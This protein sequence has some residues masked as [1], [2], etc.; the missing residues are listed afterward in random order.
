MSI[1]AALLMEGSLK[2]ISVSETCPTLRLTS[3]E[4]GSEVRLK[5]A[6]ARNTS[7][8]ALII[9]TERRLPGLGAALAHALIFNTTL[10]TLDITGAHC[11]GKAVSLL[12]E[13]LKKNRSLTSLLL[14]TCDSD[15]L[16]ALAD[17]LTQNDTLSTLTLGEGIISEE[18]ALAFAHTIQAN[19][20][21]TVLSHNVCMT[22]TFHGTDNFSSLSITVTTA[23][24]AHAL[25]RACQMNDSLE[26]LMLSTSICHTAKPGALEQLLRDNS[27]LQRLELDSVDSREASALA[28]GLRNNEVLEK[29]VIKKQVGGTDG[30]W[31]LAHILVNNIGLQTFVLGH[32]NSENGQSWPLARA[33]RTNS[34]L[35]SLT[36]FGPILSDAACA[37][38]GALASNTSLRSLVILENELDEAGAWTL[39]NAI[40]KN[41]SLHNVSLSNGTVGDAGAKAF[42]GVIAHNT[43]LQYLDL[44]N[45]G[46]SG[47]GILDIVH[48]LA[49]NT[50][51]ITLDLTGNANDRALGEE[52]AKM[53]CTVLFDGEAKLGY[54]IQRITR[55]SSVQHRSSSSSSSDVGSI[56]R[57]SELETKLDAIKRELFHK[58]EEINALRRQLR[59]EKRRS[60]PRY[61]ERANWRSREA[62]VEALLHLRMDV[63]FV[64]NWRRAEDM[65][66]RPIVGAAGNLF[67][68]TY[69][70]QMVALKQVLL[71]RAPSLTALIQGKHSNRNHS[72][73]L[74][75][76]ILLTMRHPHIVPFLGLC[77]DQADPGVVYLM[78]TWASGGS[79]YEYLHTSKAAPSR[80]ER[81]R[82]LMEMA[83]AMEYLHA[84]GVVHRDFK[85]PNVLLT[86]SL[87][88]QICD[89]GLSS[90]SEQSSHVS[91]RLGTELWASPEQ[92]AGDLL[93]RET[94]VF[95]FGCVAWE[96][97]FG[98]RPWHHLEFMTHQRR[99]KYI[100][101]CYERHVF[102]AVDKEING[103]TASPEMQDIISGCLQPIGQRY[104][105]GQLYK[106]FLIQWEAAKQGGPVNLDL[107]EEILFGADDA[108]WKLSQDVVDQIDTLL[109][110]LPDAP[111]TLVAPLRL[112]LAEHQELL[113]QVLR[114]ALAGPRSM[115]PVLSRLRDAA[116]VISHVKNAAFNGAV[117]RNRIMVRCKCDGQR[118]DLPRPFP[119][120]DMASEHHSSP[121]EIALLSYATMHPHAL[122][123]PYHF[124]CVPSPN[125][126]L[127][128]NLRIQRAFCGLPSFEAAVAILSGDMSHLVPKDGGWMGHGFYVT[129]DLDFALESAVPIAVKDRDLPR[130]LERWRLSRFPCCQLVLLCDVVY[131]NPFP[132]LSEAQVDGEK[133]MP[134]HDAHVAVVNMATKPA[135]N[136]RPFASVE[137]W[138]AEGGC[139]A[140]QLV[141]H[142][143]ASVLPHALLVFEPGP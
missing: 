129:P 139:P 141:L 120:Q 94:D 69:A 21:L 90:V 132:M 86:A 72:L 66:H 111:S 10:Q 59:R 45:N 117:M 74:E 81:S 140:V 136:A 36:L 7:L 82:M 24:S 137:D 25:I 13:T 41:K 92:F 80:A 38:A 65:R 97:V 88:T 28:S 103:R 11:E 1:P 49:W 106:A 135:S 2:A 87:S 109:A 33:L 78:M 31:A 9:E 50:Q 32:D 125:D 124:L 55:T 52:A 95:S 110:P 115:D 51:L 64:D 67:K 12:A 71:D 75:V 98:L 8:V 116:L 112:S 85:S 70:G 102:M 105:F 17:A 127:H 20:A 14:R 47:E 93:T 107:H 83:S 42:A 43:S 22:G 76:K 118:E 77:Y 29:L 100:A 16:L 30:S 23:Q 6:L 138:Q 63:S 44:S 104:D 15:G 46:I 56:S 113:H 58:D 60:M 54:N 114:K 34:T 68:G 18:A 89:F 91:A 40:K 130:T 73:L 3:L 4:P 35:T 79:L 57:V 37:L 61:D 96:M 133:L 99:I 123:S 143:G 142:D 26:Q 131:T 19:K 108:V 62:E 128:V 39:A 122:N 126:A 27:T 5:Q 121:Q 48:A 84:H 101:H 134:G 119:V 53:L